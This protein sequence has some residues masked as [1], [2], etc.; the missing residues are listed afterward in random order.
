MFGHI[1]MGYS[2]RIVSQ[3]QRDHS[4][5]WLPLLVLSG[6]STVAAGHCRRY[7]GP[8]GQ[9]LGWKLLHEQKMNW[10]GGG[11]HSRVGLHSRSCGATGEW[12]GTSCV[13]DMDMLSELRN[14][15]QVSSRLDLG[16]L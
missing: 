1:Q 5:D 4:R 11:Q 7:L 16:P 3:L 13:A 12:A 2:H 10:V 14:A 15:R 9:S 6:C 8:Q